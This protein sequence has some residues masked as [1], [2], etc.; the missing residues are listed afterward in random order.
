MSPR[1]AGVIQWMGHA[2]YNLQ[3]VKEIDGC[4]SRRGWCWMYISSRCVGGCLE[5]SSLTSSSK[6]VVYLCQRELGFQLGKLEGSSLLSNQE[7]AP[8]EPSE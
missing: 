7:R 8:W 1:D 4:S 3:K 6:S 5:G 2:V